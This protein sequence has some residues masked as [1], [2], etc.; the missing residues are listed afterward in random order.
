MASSLLYPGEPIYHDGTPIHTIKD[1]GFGRGLDLSQRGEDGYAGVAEPFPSSL[2]IPRS[3]WQARI[4]E[5]EEQ[6]AILSGLCTQAG[7]KSKNQQQTNFCWAN[8]PTYGLEVIRVVQNQT[9]VVFSPAS[10]ACPIN[11]FRNE[12]GWGKQ[13][14]EQIA[15][16]GAVPADI[17]PANAIDQRYYTADAKAQALKYRFSEWWELEPGN[18][19]QLVSTLLRGVPVAVGLG[20]W[21]HEVTF[22]DPLWLDGAIAIRF[23]NSWGDGYGSNGYGT[24]QGQKMSPDDAVAPRLAT[25]A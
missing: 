20:W 1:Y 17:W 21:G 19:D 13:A 16:A 8:A 6:K 23:R 25:A 10:V 12:G 22:V 14:L 15:K 4:A 3:E 2:M 7:L 5:R 18:I 11:G 24:L 9:P